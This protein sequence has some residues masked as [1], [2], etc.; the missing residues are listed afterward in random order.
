MEFLKEFFLFLKER[1]K[2]WLLPL[3]LI[4]AVVGG[5]LILSKG[6]ILSP[7]IYTLF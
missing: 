6:S 7:F 1:K 2:M 3:I 5:L 4:L